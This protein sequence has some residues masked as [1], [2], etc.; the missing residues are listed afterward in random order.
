[1]CAWEEGGQGSCVQCSNGAARLQVYAQYVAMVELS[2]ETFCAGHHVT[3]EELFGEVQSVLGAGGLDDEFLPAVL[4]VAEYA[5]FLEQMVLTADRP[6]HLLEAAAG[7]A[8]AASAE[9]GGGGEKEAEVGDIA[10]RLAGLTGVWVVDKQ[11]THFDGLDAYLA[12]IRVPAVFRGL[13][14]GSFYS[15]KHVVVLQGPT[16]IA[17]IASSPFGAQR[18]DYCL[19]GEVSA[20]VCTHPPLRP[21]NSST[22]IRSQKNDQCF[23]DYRI[24]C[25][26]CLA[27][28][29]TEEG[30]G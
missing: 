25:C 16:A 4:R 21:G 28:S 10:G 19:D 20:R 22:D 12:S 11:R 27:A 24:T 26:F 1:M 15:N 8:A 17:L 18:L 6:Q 9:A 7:Q 3:S 30:G 13:A 29:I 23:Q 14:K 5:Y 2:L